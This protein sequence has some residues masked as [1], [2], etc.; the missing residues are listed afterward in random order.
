MRENELP[1]TRA[2]TARAFDQ[3]ARE[4]PTS[5]TGNPS[6]VAQLQLENARLRKL[7]TDL[8][9]EKMRL[10]DDQANVHATTARK[11]ASKRRPLQESV[12]AFG[13]CAKQYFSRQNENTSV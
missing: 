7:V 5:E 9:L 8:L 6:A 13:V 10:E 4:G 1:R 12:T 2:K 3:S 11:P